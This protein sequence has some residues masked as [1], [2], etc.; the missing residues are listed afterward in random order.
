MLDPEQIVAKAATENGLR[1]E[2]VRSVAAVESAFRTQA[3][4]PERGDRFDAAYAWH[5]Q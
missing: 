2:F 4:S 1:P 3:V 5:C